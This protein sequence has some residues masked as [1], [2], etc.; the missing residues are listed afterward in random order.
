MT[1]LREV[2]IHCLPLPYIREVPIH[3]LPLSY[4][5]EVPIHSLPLMYI[6]EGASEWQHRHLKKKWEDILL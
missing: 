6:R 2:A 4:I 5:R 1:Y 3:C